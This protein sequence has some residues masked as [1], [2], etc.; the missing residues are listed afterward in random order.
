[1]S[2]SQYEQVTEAA[3]KLLFLLD[4]LDGFAHAPGP[5]EWACEVCAAI[6]ELTELV[7]P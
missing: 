2:K 3:R 1:M 6:D 5:R 7:D 4:E